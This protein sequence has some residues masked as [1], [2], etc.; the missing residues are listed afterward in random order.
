MYRSHITDAVQLFTNEQIIELMPKSYKLIA[1]I[2]GVEP[3]LHLID[4]YGGTIIFIP[5]K[6]ALNINHDISRVIGL[7]SLQKLADQFGNTTLEIPKG[8]P[9]LLAVRNHH[10]CELAKRE[11]KPKIARKFNLTL[12]T[13]RSIVNSPKNLSSC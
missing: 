6:H 10:I 7:T 12:R 8:N 11:S 3:A 4:A 5:S 13:I 2:I 9:I 1:Q